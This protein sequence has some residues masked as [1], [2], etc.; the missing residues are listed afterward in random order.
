MKNIIFMNGLQGSGKSYIAKKIKD[1]YNHVLNKK[2]EIISKDDYRY[3][4]DGYIFDKIYEKGIE[5]RYFEELRNKMKSEEEYIIL[6]NTH[7]S[8]TF[9]EK[10]IAEINKTGEEYRYC[11]LCI[12]PSS[13]LEWHSKQNKH[14]IDYEGMKTRYEGWKEWY[15]KEYKEGDEKYIMYKLSEEGKYF[16]DK[17]IHM[18]ILSVMNYFDK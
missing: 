3:T 11:Y 17:E 8:K 10:T 7:Y 4:K 16:T 6:D 1:Y 14:G 9:I 18:M 5:D 15:D 12:K 13:N 2:T